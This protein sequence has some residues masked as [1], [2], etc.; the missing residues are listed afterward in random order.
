ML[1]HT[2]IMKMSKVIDCFG[3][4]HVVKFVMITTKG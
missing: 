2:N 1:T 3:D 4:E